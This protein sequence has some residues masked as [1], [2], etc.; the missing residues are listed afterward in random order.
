MER[1][2]AYLAGDN[3]P[4]AERIIRD[5]TEEEA[6]HCEWLAGI[7]RDWLEQGGPLRS[8]FTDA[9][10]SRVKRLA[11]DVAASVAGNRYARATVGDILRFYK[12]TSE[13]RDD[14]QI[15]NALAADESR[16]TDD[17]LRFVTEGLRM[18]AQVEKSGSSTEAGYLQHINPA[19]FAEGTRLQGK[20]LR[21]V[22]SGALGDLFANEHARL[23]RAADD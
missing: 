19:K 8:K 3:T 16:P 7:K 13:T 11:Q 9:V 4:G 20:M 22:K 12:G 14:A 1:W 18:M 23:V 6:I 15:V 5:A 2:A 21:R 17:Q 10:N